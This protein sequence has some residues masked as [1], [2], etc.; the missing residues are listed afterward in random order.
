MQINSWL[1]LKQ[2]IVVKAKTNMQHFKHLNFGTEN[3]GTCT[4]SKLLVL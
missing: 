4:H 2:G 3:P 1:L